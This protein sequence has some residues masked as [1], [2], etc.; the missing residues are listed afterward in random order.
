MPD[1]V[2]VEGLNELRKALK[3]LGDVEATKEFKQAGYNAMA[4]VLVPA[5]QGRASTAGQTRAL[6]TLRP[7]KVVTGGAVRF[8]RGDPAAFGNEFGAMHN[9]PRQSV[10]GSPGLGWNQFPAWRRGGYTIYPAVG[11]KSDEMVA[12]FD[13]GLGPLIERLGWNK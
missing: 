7:A 2:Q 4:N 13:R 10:N 8:G 12:E 6:E 5:A 1:Q 3:Q 9:Q 11:D